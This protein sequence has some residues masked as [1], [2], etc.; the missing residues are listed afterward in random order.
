MGR[1]ESLVVFG[2][3]VVECGPRDVEI[4]GCKVHHILLFCGQG[5]RTKTGKPGGQGR[6]LQHCLCSFSVVM[7]VSPPFPCNIRVLSRDCYFTAF[8]P[9]NQSICASANGQG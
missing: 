2:T 9:E 8:L 5:W 6:V 1:G 7:A 4:G 3:E